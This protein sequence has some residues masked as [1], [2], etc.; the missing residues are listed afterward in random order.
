MTMSVSL[1]TLKGDA[2]TVSQVPARERII[3]HLDMDSFYA[4][5]EMQRRP[6]LRN[7]P[8]VIGADPKQGTG[9][10][11]VCTCSYEARAFG[12]HS[13]MPVSQAYVHCPHAIF[14]PPDF[15]YYSQVSEGIMDLLRSFGFRFLQVSIDEA[16]LDVSPCGSFVAATA[17]AEQ[18]QEMIRNRSG[19]T[20]SV[21]IA[22]GKAVAKIASDFKKPGGLTVVEPQAVREFLAP[23]PVRKIPGI[24]K[25]SEAE[26]L[27]LDITTIG[28]LA[29]TDIQVLLGRF[30]RWA[31]PLHELA[32]GTDTSEL[33]EYDGIKSVSRETTF[34]AD[35]DDPFALS[36]ALDN[37]AKSVH[38]NLAEETLRCKTVTV[39]IRYQ[40]FITRTKSC[41]LSHYTS[42]D[43][44]I[45]N[46]SR[47]LLRDMYD[48]RKV[49]LIGV[50]LSSFEKH[51]ERQTTLGV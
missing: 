46:C 6:E 29:A 12:V 36:A 11:V 3:L 48:G 51:D 23:M 47:N 10:G 4:S 21:G 31:V 19:L 30:G 1:K 41:T 26:L 27:E 33:E 40:G 8:V 25:R 2:V 34:D 9:R 17:L 43:A 24:G 18:I 35:T 28:K 39:K 37:L 15:A 49:R 45:K 16:F 42:D 7:K 32:K 22:P 13:A 50:R 20:C 44:M 5:A 38:R 14:L